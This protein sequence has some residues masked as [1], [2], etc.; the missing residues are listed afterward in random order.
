MWRSS[1]NGRHENAKGKPADFVPQSNCPTQAKTGLEWATRPKRSKRAILSGCRRGQRHAMAAEDLSHLC[2]TGGGSGPPFCPAEGD[3]STSPRAGWSRRTALPAKS[4]RHGTPDS[5]SAQPF[6]VVVSAVE[7]V[8]G[9]VL[10]EF[11]LGRGGRGLGQQRGH[12]NFIH[13]FEAACGIE[14]LMENLH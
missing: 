5:R 4:Q 9:F 3:A 12:L 7:I 10:L 1:R 11:T 8:S 13:R 2:G 6:R 14:R